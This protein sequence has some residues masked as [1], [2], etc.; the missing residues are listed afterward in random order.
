MSGRRGRQM[1]LP[2]AWC[3]WRGYVGAEM[4]VISGVLRFDGAMRKLDYPRRYR[5]LDS[6][7]D[8]VLADVAG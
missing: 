8:A 3:W 7:V 2:A 5:L 4:V 1:R 6:V